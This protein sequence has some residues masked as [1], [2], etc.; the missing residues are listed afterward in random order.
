MGIGIGVLGM[1]SISLICVCVTYCV[2]RN[3][4]Y[5]LKKYKKKG[6]PVTM[7]LKPYGEVGDSP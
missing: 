4:G 3:M 1:M 2:F 5:E 6:D 7:K